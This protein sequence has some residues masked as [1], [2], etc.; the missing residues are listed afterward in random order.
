MNWTRISRAV[1]FSG[2]IIVITAAPLGMS[3]DD[4]R[5]KIDAW[6]RDY[7]EIRSHSAIGN[8]PPIAL[9]NGSPASP[10]HEPQP[11]HFQFRAGLEVGHVAA[12]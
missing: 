4:V 6:H 10:P 3:L 2:T 11:R 8:N 7:S 5:T 1:A 12:A 9:M